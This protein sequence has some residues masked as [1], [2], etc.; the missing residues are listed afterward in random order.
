MSHHF[1]RLVDLM[2]TLRAPGGC[3]WD[4]KQSHDSLKPYLL[5]ET[6]EALEAIDLGDPRKLTEELGDVLLQVLFHS[7]IAREHG[8]FSIDDVLT[9]LA[10]KLVR[11]HPHVFGKTAT[12]TPMDADQ[13]VHRWEDIKRHER[14]QSGTPASSFDG[15]PK[16]LPAL[17]RAYQI[18][19]RAARVGFDWAHN[20]QGRHQVLAKVEEEVGELRQHLNGQDGSQDEPRD[21]AEHRERIA[22]LGD[23][24]FSVVNVARHLHVNPEDALRQ[25]TD[26][27][28]NRFR[29]MEEHL[30]RSGRSMATLSLEDMDALW[31]QV[32]QEE[33]G[34]AAADGRSN[35]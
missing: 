33:R 23:L 7:Q 9:L 19:A 16:T 5:E 10:T 28:M 15:V 29:M 27:F 14:E 24:L 18:Q 20:T 13:V 4:R 3:P 31:E 26:R 35:G 32:K 17:L 21:T 25:A 12:E 22:E 1:D 30:A 34:N 11:R 6:Y 8:T 2:A